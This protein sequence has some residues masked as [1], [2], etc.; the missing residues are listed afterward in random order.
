MKKKNII[1]DDDVIKQFLR[2]AFEDNTDCGNICDV[3]EGDNVDIEFS[4]KHKVKMN[5]LFREMVGGGYIPFPEVDTLTERIRS[6]AVVIYLRLK[7]RIKR[8]K[9]KKI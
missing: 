7:E 8:G 5:R 1:V 2:S 3:S 6:G 4:Y 9:N